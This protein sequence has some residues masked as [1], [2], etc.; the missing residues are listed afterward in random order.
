MMLSGKKKD[1]DEAHDLFIQTEQ[2]TSCKT[3][4]D[5]RRWKKCTKAK[6]LPNQGLKMN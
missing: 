3:L 6:S 5:I 1:P 4:Q 2:N